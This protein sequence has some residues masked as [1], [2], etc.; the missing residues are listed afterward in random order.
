M[1]NVMLKKAVEW[2][3]SERMPCAIRLLPT[4][5]PSAGFY[6]FDEYERLLQIAKAIDDNTY[7]IVLLGGDAGLRCGENAAL[8]APPSGCDSECDQI[9]GRGN[10]GNEFYRDRELASVE[11]FKWRGRRDSCH[12]RREPRDA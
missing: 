8:H 11:W 2:D 3:V 10:S 12:A 6:D 1:L 5:K 4:P 9:V 7:L